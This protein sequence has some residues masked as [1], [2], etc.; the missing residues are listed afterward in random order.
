MS[1]LKPFG[2]LKKLIVDGN[3]LEVLKG[4]LFKFNPSVNELNFASNDIYSIDF[5]VFDNLKLKSVDF[6]GNVC[7]RRQMKSINETLREIKE[8]C[9][10]GGYSPTFYLI[11][12][13]VWTVLLT[14]FMYL[15]V[16]GAVV[17]VMRLKYHKKVKIEF[18]NELLSD[19]E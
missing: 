8:K 6:S 18:F 19:V 10:V 3:E 14:T 17:L 12:T 5:N 7:M 11:G 13:I 9:P 15:F 4:D 16:I 2:E 1:D